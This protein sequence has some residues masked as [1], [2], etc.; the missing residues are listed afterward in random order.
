[1]SYGKGFSEFFLFLMVVLAI[2]LPL[3]IW[4]LVEICVWVYDNLSWGAK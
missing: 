3:G 1:M 4:K 2:S